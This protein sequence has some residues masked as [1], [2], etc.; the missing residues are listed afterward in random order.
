MENTKIKYKSVYDSWIVGVGVS[1][2]GITPALATATQ[3]LT[4]L[5]HLHFHTP[6]T[7]TGIT[8]RKQH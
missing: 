4:N 6:S 1:F 7:T 5:H 8:A 2:C 3:I